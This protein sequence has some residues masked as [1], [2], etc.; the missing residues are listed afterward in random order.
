MYTEWRKIKRIHYNMHVYY[1]WGFLLVLSYLINKYSFSHLNFGE[2]S[3]PFYIGYKSVIK[4]FITLSFFMENSSIKLSCQ[5]I[6][7][8]CYSMDVTCQVEIKLFHGNYLWIP[9]TSSTTCNT[10]YIATV[11]TVVQGLPLEENKWDDDDRKTRN[12]DKTHWM[13]TAYFSYFTEQNM[14][15]LSSQN[16]NT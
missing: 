14:F 6:I 1:L 10:Q 16:M 15:T 5:E 4:W 2:T 11:A 13:N 8:C 3:L 7:G 12:S 9:S